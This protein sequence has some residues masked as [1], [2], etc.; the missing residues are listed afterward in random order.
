LDA[1]HPENGVLIP[2][3]FTGASVSQKLTSK[4]GSKAVVVVELVA[5]V[6]A[7]GKEPEINLAS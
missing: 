7:R 5:A 4:P 1:D 6:Q 2:R 3:L